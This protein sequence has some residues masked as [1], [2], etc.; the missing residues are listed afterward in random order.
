LHHQRRTGGAEP[1][2]SR[3]PFCSRS[4]SLS[5]FGFRISSRTSVA[6]ARA[7]TRGS[8][9][10]SHEVTPTSGQ[11]LV[12]AVRLGRAR[13]M[14]EALVTDALGKRLGFVAFARASATHRLNRASAREGGWLTDP[15]AGSSQVP[16]RDHIRVARASPVRSER[17]S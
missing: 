10:G 11:T 7:D 4:S 12:E 15:V 17:E 2:R 1:W 8:P 3:P 5:R 13:T 6:D 16:D 14:R 9:G